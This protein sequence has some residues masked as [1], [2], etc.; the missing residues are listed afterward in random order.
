MNELRSPVE[1]N[2]RPRR[3][4][5]RRG[6]R[7]A[8]PVGAMLLFVLTV[9]AVGVA[10]AAA[11]PAPSLQAPIEAAHGLASWRR[12]TALEAGL[13]LDMGGKRALEGTLLMETTGGRAR[14]TLRDGTVAVFDGREAYVAPATAPLRMARFHLRT[15][16]YFLALPFKLSDPGTRIEA[17]GSR[18]FA[19]RPAEALRLSFL[20]G[21]GD[22]PDDWYLLYA[23]P[24]THR[25]LGATYIVT[26][27]G[28]RATAE[29]RPNAVRFDD[30]VTVDGVTLATRFRFHEWLPEGRM[31]DAASGELLLTNPRFVTPAAD[32]FAAPSGAR[33]DPA[34]HAAATDTA[35]FAGGCFWCV[36]TAFEGLP[37]VLSVV[38]GYTGGQKRD[39]TY[40]EVGG[41]RTGHAEAVQIIFDPRAT[42][43][44][45]LLDVFWHNIDPTQANGQ[46]CDHGPQYRS[47]IFTHDA[48]QRLLAEESR[49]RLEAAPRRFQEKF[50]TEI[51]AAGRFYRAEEYHQDYYRKNPEHYREYREGCGRDRR[52]EQLWG[53]PGRH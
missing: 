4:D 26:Y 41:G 14:L 30:P 51:V 48:A 11:P 25:L 53:A 46:F 23:D 34:P 50:V 2:A 17:L 8:F 32:A 33:I 28:D 43:Y 16:A 13:Q 20:S 1:S 49:R 21:T 36:E 39:P 52:L 15:W 47:A 40:E 7:A 9:R 6:H 22:S 24:A 37:G 45:A 29:A 27:F 31:A 44:A 18:P 35:T 38:S 19:E 12:T 5:I 42:G 10:G 3:P